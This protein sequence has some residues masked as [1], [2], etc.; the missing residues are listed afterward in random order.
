MYYHI[1]K[2]SITNCPRCHI[3][4]FKEKIHI[5]EDGDT[6]N[7]FHCTNC[8]IIYYGDDMPILYLTVEYDETKAIFNSSDGS[9]LKYVK[10]SLEWNI[11]ENKCI[12]THWINGTR[13]ESIINNLPI[14]TS[15]EKI[16]QYMEL[17]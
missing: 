11:K 6:S 16:K 1:S 5:E 14:D 17:L 12:S 15:I 13:Y 10:W 8:D 2:C 3:G 9:H 7:S 4:T